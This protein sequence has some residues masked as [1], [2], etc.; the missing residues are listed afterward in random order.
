MR[1]FNEARQ[2]TVAVLQQNDALLAR[3]VLIDDVFGRI[4]V[5]VWLAEEANRDAV[6]GLRE[7]LTKAAGPFWA[8]DLWLANGADTADQQVYEGVWAEGEEKTQKLRVSERSR[9]RGF[10]LEAPSQPAWSLE[11]QEKSAPIVAFYS[12]KGGVGRTTALASFAILRAQ[13]GERVAVLDL[14][15][16]APGVGLLLSPASLPGPA[17]RISEDLILG[18][19]IEGSPLEGTDPHGYNHATDSSSLGPPLDHSGSLSA[20][21]SC[22]VVD[23]LLEAPLIEELDLKDYYHVCAREAVT[24]AGEIMVFPSGNMD[25][26]YLATLAR[27]DLEPPHAG[28]DHP[29]LRLLQQVRDE[30]HPNW[31]LL[32]CRAGLS[33]ASGFALSGLAHLTVLLGTTSDQ[34]WAGLDLVLGRLGGDRVRKSKPQSQ[35]LIVHAMVPE[36]P[37]VGQAAKE[38]FAARAAEEFERF[39][40]AEDPSDPDEDGYWYVR[41]METDDAPHVPVTLSYTPR[42]AFLRSIEDAVS[43]FQESEYRALEVRISSRFAKEES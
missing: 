9:T 28:K 33:E 42:L 18:S 41:D 23:Y 15:L 1:H 40:Y 12:F 38:Q 26:D 3:A 22:G 37:S 4:R 34:S 25:S 13:Q 36:Y 29:L 43:V 6:E 27:L 5:V 19:P 11:G 24:G 7:E 17:L 20:A 39:Y 35:C 10:W 2:A 16:D 31:I 14:D 21:S 30:L 8:G 32:D